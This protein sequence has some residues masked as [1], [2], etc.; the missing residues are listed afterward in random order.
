MGTRASEQRHA[1]NA[2]AQ[3]RSPI[4]LDGRSRMTY[5]PGCSRLLSK[6]KCPRQHR[7][8]RSNEV[9]LAE[10]EHRVRQTVWCG[11]PGLAAWRREAVEMACR[12][13]AGSRKLRVKKIMSKNSG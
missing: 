4:H 9:R 13:S 8:W 3:H 5:M 2:V 1:L 12:V 6:R 11:N 10:A 7:W